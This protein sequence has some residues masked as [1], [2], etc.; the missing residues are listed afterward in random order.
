M[1]RPSLTNYKCLIQNK[2]EIQSV[3]MRHKYDFTK[4]KNLLQSFCHT[5]I[6]SVIFNIESDQ[7]K[8]FFDGKRNP[9]VL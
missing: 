6:I 8:I 7:K 4:L 1:Q 5:N 9:L 3:L 2:K